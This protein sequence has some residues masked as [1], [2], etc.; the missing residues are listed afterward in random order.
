MIQ[1]PSLLLPNHPMSHKEQQALVEMVL[2][3]SDGYFQFWKLI[4]SKKGEK[5]RHGCVRHQ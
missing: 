4:E 3:L 5:Q 2:G 1:N